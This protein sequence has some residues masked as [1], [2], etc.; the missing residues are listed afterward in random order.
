MLLLFI[1]AM[2][3][4]I[5][6]N[7]AADI[8]PI[9]SSSSLC[10]VP[11][12]IKPSLPTITA[13][14]MSSSS[15]NRCRIV[16]TL[17]LLYVC[18]LLANPLTNLFCFRINKKERFSGDPPVRSPGKGLRPIGADLSDSL[19]PAAAREEKEK[20]GITCPPDPG[21]GL[22]PLHP[23]KSALMGFAPCTPLAFCFFGH[24]QGLVVGF[25]CL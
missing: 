17:S 25:H 7:A 12:T 3:L 13:P 20:L 22:R 11:V 2:K 1:W 10:S 18:C 4:V 24:G 23:L 6:P 15:V 5:E 21:R 14:M 9:T 19:P 16:S 8:A